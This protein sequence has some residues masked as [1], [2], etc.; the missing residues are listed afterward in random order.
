MS[1]HAMI[2]RF[3][4]RMGR[5]SEMEGEPR[6]A[7]RIFAL[8]LMTPGTLSL[9]EIAER[10]SISKGSVSTNARALARHGLLER[11]SPPSERRD[12]YG[13]GEDLY[14][15]VLESRLERMEED[16]VIFAEMAKLAEELDPVVRK[17]ISEMATAFVEITNATQGLLAAWRKR[18]EGEEEAS[19][20]VRE[21]RF[22]R[23]VGN[24]K[25]QR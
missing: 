13:V 1:D 5:R 25:I 8:L 18:V 7:G 2:D 3:V 19:R 17:R 11:H 21:R 9:D 6:T 10:L 16:R 20:G 24:T 12:F 15:R 4:E 14:T 23:L 22:R